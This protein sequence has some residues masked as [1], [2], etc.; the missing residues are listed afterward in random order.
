[1]YILT[2]NR[3]RIAYCVDYEIKEI[4]EIIENTKIR[5]QSPSN[6]ELMAR[7]ITNYVFQ[8]KYIEELIK[9]GKLSQHD[10]LNIKLASYNRIAYIVQRLQTE[11]WVKMGYIV[12]LM[13]GSERGWPPVKPDGADIENAIKANISFLYDRH[14]NK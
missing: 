4:G 1:M 7:S 5:L 3:K 6:L 9:D 14:L 8:N 2:Q 11:D 10:M 12:D 13:K